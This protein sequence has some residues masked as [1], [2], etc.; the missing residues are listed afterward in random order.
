MLSYLSA[1]EWTGFI[2]LADECRQS[3]A[4]VS[5]VLSLLEMRGRIEKT[6]LYFHIRSELVKL[7]RTVHPGHGKPYQGFEFG[8]RLK[9]RGIKP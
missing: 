8:Y 5:R 6:P 7:D 3:V 4:A 2:G 1:T 9:E